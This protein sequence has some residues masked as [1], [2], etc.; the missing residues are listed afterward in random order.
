MKNS[1]ITIADNYRRAYESPS[2]AVYQMC[3]QHTL[4]SVSGEEKTMEIFDDNEE[5]WP[6]DPNTNLPF[7]PW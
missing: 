6:V 5:E 4:L 2:M 7:S 3:M 1:I